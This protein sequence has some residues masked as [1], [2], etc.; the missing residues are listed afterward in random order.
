MGMNSQTKIPISHQ[1]ETEFA[2]LVGG[3][4]NVRDVNDIMPKIS[5]MK[6]GALMNYAPSNPELKRLNKMFPHNGKWHTI[7]QA[8]NETHID[9]VTIRNRSAKSMT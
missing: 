2:N 8:E 6:W 9:N 5:G 4:M 3:K 7:I 1:L